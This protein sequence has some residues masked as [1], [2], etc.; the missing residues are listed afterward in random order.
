MYSTNSPLDEKLRASAQVTSED[1]AVAQEQAIVEPLRPGEAV[2]HPRYGFGVVRGIRNEGMANFTEQNVG[3]VTEP[4]YEI[5]ITG[6]GTLFVPT[7]RA[8]LVGLRRLSNSLAVISAC[9]GSDAVTLPDEARPRLAG[10]RQREQAREPEALA[11]AV[12]DL[13]ASRRNGSLTNPERKWLEQACRRL[14]AEAAIIEH[15]AES[16]AYAAIV[17]AVAAAGASFPP[18]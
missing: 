17:A 10:L 6:E 7:N 5:D 9:L 14:S 4:Y 16:E 18:T 2:Y 13:I 15:M 3:G 1:W 12:R 8:E 11:E